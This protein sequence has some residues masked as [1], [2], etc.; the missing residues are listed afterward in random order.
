MIKYNVGCGK[1]NFGP[2]WWHVDGGDFD[3]LLHN[4]VFLPYETDNVIDLLYTSHL[5]CYF[6]RYEIKDLL[7]SWYKKIKPGGTLRIATPDYDRLNWLFHCGVE[8]SRISGPLFGRWQM[9]DKVI[10]HKTQYTE[11]ELTAVLTE[12]G[13]INIERYDHR[14]TEHPNTGD[15]NDPYDDHSCAYIDKCL[16]SLNMQCLKPI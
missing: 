13:F 14:K 5:I 8:F 15:R 10:F 11:K 9:G 7:A 2:S 3:H 4:D 1:R 12:A 16:V 6:D